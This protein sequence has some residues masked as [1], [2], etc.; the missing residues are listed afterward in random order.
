MTSSV[1]AFKLHPPAQPP[2]LLTRP[3]LLHR[4]DAATEPVVVVSAPAGAGKT[5]LLTEWSRDL[6]ARGECAWLSLDAYDNAPDRLWAGILRALQQAR[7]DL[8]ARLGGGEWTAD[9]WLDETL[10]TLLT[11]LGAAGPL[12]LILDG[13]ES[14]TDADAQRTLADFLTRLPHGIRIVLSTRHIPGSPLPA[15]R[16]RGLIAE[17]DQHD[18]AF[19]R[20]ESRAVLTGL[21]GSAPTAESSRALHE[22]T[23]GWAAGLCI[24][25]R[26]L[27]RSGN[28]A[29]TEGHLAR[30]RQAITEYLATEVLDR[31]TTE[32]RRF[33][34]LTSVLDELSAGP[35]QALAGDRAGVLLRELARTVQ[36]LVPVAAEA[37]A[38]RHHRALAALLSDVL[39]SEGSDTV[40]ALHRSVAQW[41][42]RQ[43]RTTEAVR[44]WTQ[45]GEESA[46]VASVL[47]GWE[48]AVS[49]GRGV[50]VSQW[51]DMLPHRTVAADARLCVV[52]AMTALANGAPETA[53]RWLDVALLRQTGAQT[54][55]EGGTVCYAAA[56]AQAIACCLKGE[57]L[58]ADRLGESAVTGTLPLTSWRALAG[59]ARGAALLWT[60]RY[61]EA[62][63]LLGEA[64]RDAHAAG[65]GLA[66]VRAL[67]LRTLC[68]HLAGRRE[69][70]H[71]LSEEA[72]QEIATVGLDRHF[73]SVPAYVGRAGLLLQEVRLD[74][75]EQ[76][77]AD[78]EAAL[79]GSPRTESEPHV[80]AL[81][82][83]TRSRLESARRDTNAAR[84]AREAAER[85]A[86]RCE[87]PGILTDLLGRADGAT[88]VTP[89]APRPQDLSLGER[90]VLRALC[91]SLTLREIASELYVSH[92]TVKTQVRAIFRK[93]DAH[94]RSEAVARARECGV[95]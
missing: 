43:G 1:P 92:N 47:D 34:L 55:G 28:A 11:G 69:L 49:A 48:T 2:H 26:A 24:M 71:I 81:W 46:A 75:A 44:H 14:V 8:P 70:A 40:A 19:T 9:T 61:E 94:D 16:A 57:V 64:T 18:L 73:V 50:Q 36:L 80:R 32:Q 68:A 17:L 65:H 67:G 90:R 38:Y 85:A 20:E 6:A 93:L 52:A 84:K 15:L 21:L 72:L 37:S 7:P 56:V 54:V 87:S 30:G 58:T 66:L 79:A 33:L 83:F 86:A 51:L 23:E 78:A 35:C 27:A 63:V 82:H 3:R 74:E 29:D 31:L 12:T 91:G 39:E 53:C 5:V 42:S 25:G 22:A 95:L 88:A 77:L 13:L 59:T 4:L 89:A 76:A 60:G 45:G 62:E 41:Y 10:P